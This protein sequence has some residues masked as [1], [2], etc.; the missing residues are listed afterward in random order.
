MAFE[1]IEVEKNE[2]VTT[3]RINRPQVMNAIHPPAM[4]ELDA[5]FNDFADDPEQWIAVLTATGEKAFCAGNDLKW[6]AE[7]GPAEVFQCI[8]EC[9]GGFGGLHARFDCFKPI[10]GAINGLALGGGF[11]LV[12]CCDI[13][14]AAEN[15]SFA[16][17]EPTVGMMAGAGGVHRL[18]RQIGFRKAMGMMLTAQRITAQEALDMG[19]VNEVVPLEE[20]GEATTRW[21][22]GILKCAP[23][24]VRATKEAAMKGLDI[25][26]EEAV[27]AVYDGMTAMFESEDLLEGPQA[28]AEKRP[29]VWKGR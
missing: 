16:L 9:R 7:N 1:F 10:V 23:L 20:L 22:E 13:V 25:G 18:P 2:R 17:P 8:H 6:Q 29:P 19:L 5:A 12:L 11:E 24:S 15:A 28:F 26:L 14:I 21:V 3:V 4:R 27:Q